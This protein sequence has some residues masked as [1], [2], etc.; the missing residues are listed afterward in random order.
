MVECRLKCVQ[1]GYVF[2]VAGSVIDGDKLKCPK[3]GGRVF[4]TSETIR[5]G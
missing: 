5:L 1:C 3:C 2:E 4:E